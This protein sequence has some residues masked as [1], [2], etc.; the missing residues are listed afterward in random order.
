[1]NSNLAEVQKRNSGTI[2][3]Q[4]SDISSECFVVADDH[5]SIQVG[6]GD[7]LEDFAGHLKNLWSQRK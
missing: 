4:K 5:L 6:Q 1:M 3:S 7:P 2:L